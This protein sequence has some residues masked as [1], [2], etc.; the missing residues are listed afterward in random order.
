[1]ETRRQ[2]KGYSQQHNREIIV[3]WVAT[4]KQKNELLEKY[5]EITMNKTY[6]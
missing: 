4:E 1:M 5:L 6:N 3:H 2:V